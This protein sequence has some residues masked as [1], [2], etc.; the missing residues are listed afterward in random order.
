MT[1]AECVT[2][3]DGKGGAGKEALKVGS[4]GKVANALWGSLK[5]SFDGRGAA[6]WVDKDQ[7]EKLNVP[8]AAEPEPEPAAPVKASKPAERG[9]P[10]TVVHSGWSY[11]KGGNWGRY[12]K[13]WFVLTADKMMAYYEEKDRPGTKK[14]DIDLT[15]AMGASEA[16]SSYMTGPNAWKIDCSERTWQLY[17][18][19]FDQRKQWIATITNMIKGQAT[20][21][22]V[23][24]KEAAWGFNM[25]T[26]SSMA[27][28]AGDGLK[29]LGSAVVT[30]ASDY[31]SEEDKKR[32][33]EQL[34]MDKLQVDDPEAYAAEVKRKEEAAKKK[35]E[36]A[37]KYKKKAEEHA[38]AVT[39]RQEEE[40]QKVKVALW[41][42]RKTIESGG[43]FGRQEPPRRGRGSGTDRDLYTVKTG[44]KATHCPKCF[45]TGWMHESS[46]SCERTGIG[47]KC[48]FCK[49]CDACDGMGLH[50]W[51]KKVEHST[52]YI[53]N[54]FTDGFGNKYE[55]LAD[56]ETTR[57][58]NIKYN[59]RC[60]H[61]GGSG[62][63]HTSDMSHDEVPWG[64]NNCF[65]C[66]KCKECKG[67]GSVEATMDF[68]SVSHRY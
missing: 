20:P 35:A 39:K 49:K 14:G 51:D 22:K 10:K 66:K 52:E 18:D 6:V 23:E 63:T 67:K 4:T 5:I 56:A 53:Y 25:A 16:P 64:R 13:R 50:A 30:M 57:N 12:Q 60:A 7:W 45:G 26:L 15:T 24:Q 37:Q 27:N 21:E 17:T 3:Q 43:G 65:F 9:D 68:S 1:G 28:K 41:S 54:N 46:M 31:M 47:D 19:T 61:C 44:S 59:R 40:S 58:T 62:W 2:G 42:K 29:S 32:E 11:K 48:F 8:K 34:R 33:A 38:K 55:W 36:E